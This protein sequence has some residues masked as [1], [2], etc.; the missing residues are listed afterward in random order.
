MK[1]TASVDEEKVENYLR[2]EGITTYIDEGFIEGIH[3]DDFIEAVLK[4]IEFEVDRDDVEVTV[5][6]D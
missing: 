4:N 3:I 6:S 5:A 1:V 2:D